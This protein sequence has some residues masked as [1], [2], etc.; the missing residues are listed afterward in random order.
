MKEEKTALSPDTTI[1]RTPYPKPDAYGALSM[2]VYQ[3][4]AYEFQTAEQME[5]AFTGKSAEHTYSRISNPSVQYFENRIKA[6][7]GANDVIAFNSG[8]AAIANALMA[9]GYAGG[10]IVSSP[11]LF[12]NTYS[13][14]ASTLKDFGLEPRFCDLT[15]PEEVEARIDEKTCAVFLEAI[16]N[17]QMEIVDLKTLSAL[18]KEKGAPLIVDSTIVPFTIFRAKDFGVDIEVVSSTKYIS[19]GATSLGGLILDYN[20]YDWK[21]SPK[22]SALVGLFGGS[23][24]STKIRREIHRNLGASMSPQAASFQTLGLE[25]LSVRYRQAAQTCRE[26]AERLFLRDDVASVN[27]PGLKNHPFHATGRSQFGEF[28]GA[29]FTFDLASRKAC[30][31][32][33]DSLRLIRRATNLFDNKT[34]A[35]HPAST[36]FGSFPEEVRRYMNISQQTIRVSVGLEDVDDL[37][38]DVEQALK[39]AS[40]E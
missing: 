3:T 19:G 14:I 21:R 38:N 25:S 29:M 7:T 24:F 6:L 27:Y 37:F 16:A 31:R 20:A 26:L 39:A 28:P 36:I 32:F 4:V 35:L 9:I 5:R 17:P 30:F 1:L 18:C 12:G 40:A 2:P 23:A 22:L 11:H 33:I 15:K 10:N 8:M 34:L 13:L